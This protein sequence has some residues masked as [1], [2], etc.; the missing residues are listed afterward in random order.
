MTAPGAAPNVAVF[1]SLSYAFGDAGVQLA[2]QPVADALQVMVDGGPSATSFL[3]R[4]LNENFD[5]VSTTGSVDV[6]FD[7]AD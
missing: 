2:S 3:V 1:G 4:K 5:N 7:L 6:D